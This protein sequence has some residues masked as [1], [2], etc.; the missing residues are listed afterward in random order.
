MGRHFSVVVHVV[1][2]I[3]PVRPVVGCPKSRRSVKD[4]GQISLVEAFIQP[5]LTLCNSVKYL[6]QIFEINI[7][8]I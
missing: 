1:Y 2:C 5:P 6:T 4:V 7:S 8:N 3:H